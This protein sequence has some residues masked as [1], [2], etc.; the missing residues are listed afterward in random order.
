MPCL[1][2]VKYRFFRFNKWIKSFFSASEQDTFSLL[3][4][5]RPIQT[6]F[7]CRK[8]QPLQQCSLSLPQ[9][10]STKTNQ[11]EKVSI[12]PLVSPSGFLWGVGSSAYQTEGAWDKDG[13]GPSIWDAFTHR[14]G[15]VLRNETGDSTCDGYYK[16]KVLL[17]RNSLLCKCSGAIPWRFPILKD[18][19]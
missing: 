11:Q 2:T 18:Q 14:K 17:K 4:I 12:T 1:I 16:V 5:F 15:K 7:E 6:H 9:T 8:P 19:L 3:P 10:F 13:K